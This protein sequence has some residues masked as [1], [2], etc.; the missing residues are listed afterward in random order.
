MGVRQGTLL[1]PMFINVDVTVI[2]FL[3][4][5]ECAS[6]DTNDCHPLATCTNTWGGFRY[7]IFTCLFITQFD[8]YFIISI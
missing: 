2:V 1:D 3:D 6:S 4:L 5:D 7:I 8:H